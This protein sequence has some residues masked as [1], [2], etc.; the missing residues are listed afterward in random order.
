VVETRSKLDRSEQLGEFPLSS[1]SHEFAEC[2]VDRF[3]L[4]PE[5][6]H[7]LSFFKQ[8]IVDLK[9]GGYGYTRAHTLGVSK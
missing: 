6:A 4:G 1:S 9:V 8:A 5:S 7:L 3:S 2:L